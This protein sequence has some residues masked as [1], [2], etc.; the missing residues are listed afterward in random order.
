MFSKICR[1]LI[2]RAYQF[3][4]YPKKKQEVILNRT[5]T[6]CRHLYNNALAER[7]RQADL[8]RLKKQFDVF[9]WGKPE[10]IYYEDQA[11]DLSGSKTDFQKG[12]HSQVL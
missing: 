11:N 2:I 6:T 4:I 10:W 7:K 9:P 5:L 12:V 1:C 8:N 3:R